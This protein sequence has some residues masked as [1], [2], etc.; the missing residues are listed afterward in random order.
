MNKILLL[1][2]GELSKEMVRTAELILGKVDNVDFLTLPAGTDIAK[3]ELELRDKIE[4]APDGV[5][6]MTDLFGG[7][8]F[9]KVSGL[10]SSLKNKDKV[11]II[12]GMNLIMVLTA[13]SMLEDADIN[14]LKAEAM[15]CSYEGIVDLKSKVGSV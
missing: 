5:L 12:T 11:E 8:P 10:Y 14:E 6:V 9:I 15:K 2:H 3:Y 1:S 4:S 13:M 7:T